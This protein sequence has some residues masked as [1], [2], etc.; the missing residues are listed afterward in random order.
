MNN[1]YCTTDCYSDL[2]FMGVAYDP[3]CDPGFC[4]FYTNVMM[5][6]VSKMSVVVKV[7]PSRGVMS[8]GVA[9]RS[10]QGDLNAGKRKTVLEDLLSRSSISRVTPIFS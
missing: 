5:R 1:A 3:R 7:C 10:E 4:D 2:S 6:V 8:G 9:H